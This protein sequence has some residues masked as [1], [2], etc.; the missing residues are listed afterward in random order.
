MC[1]HQKLWPRNVGFPAKPNEGFSIL[2]TYR[3]DFAE[4][5]PV[6]EVQ[7]EEVDLWHG[8]SGYT[9]CAQLI[10]DSVGSSLAL[11]I[12]QLCYITDSTGVPFGKARYSQGVDL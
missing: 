2:G 3:I 5:N 11:D 1:D 8:G 4:K 9:S 7:C 6:P 12:P 10:V